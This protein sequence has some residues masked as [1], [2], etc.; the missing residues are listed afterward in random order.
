M[1]MTI[2]NCSFSLCY[3]IVSR[4]ECWRWADCS[5]HYHQH[6]G[7]L[8]VGVDTFLRTIKL[9]FVDFTQITMIKMAMMMTNM[10]IFIYSW[11]P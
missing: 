9:I 8:Q 2:A 11:L 10:M 5:H 6:P 4:C 7:N 3:S 1:I